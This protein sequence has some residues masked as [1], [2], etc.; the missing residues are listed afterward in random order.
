MGRSS[1]AKNLCCELAALT[2]L[3]GSRSSTCFDLILTKE[4]WLKSSFFT[5]VMK[6]R[7]KSDAPSQ[8][9]FPPNARTAT[10]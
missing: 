9:F 3:I 10:F 5:N 2:V 6:M 1:R 8:R 7:R 4:I